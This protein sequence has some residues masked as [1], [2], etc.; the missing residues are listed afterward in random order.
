MG[1]LD[2]SHLTFVR[3]LGLF[4]FLRIVWYIACSVLEFLRSRLFPADFKGFGEWASEYH[5]NCEQMILKIM[6]FGDH[7]NSI[8]TFNHLVRLQIFCF[9]I[10]VDAEK[11]FV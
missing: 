2:L 6:W 7:D 9:N 5:Q 1:F 10:S 8:L 11:E 4:V 3:Y